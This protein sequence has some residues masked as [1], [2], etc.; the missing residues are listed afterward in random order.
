MDK[1]LLCSVCKYR[2]KVSLFKMVEDGQSGQ[3]HS[4][5]APTQLAMGAAQMATAMVGQLRVKQTGQL[6]TLRVGQQTVG[7]L[8]PTSKAD[9]KIG[10][11]TYNDEY[12][13]RCHARIDVV[14]TPMGIEHRLI[15]TG[16]VN[17]PA[18]NGKALMHGD[19]VVLKFGDVIRL[20][21]T[22]IILE[23]PCGV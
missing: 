1:T 18:V 15:E 2:A 6:F 11:A 14:Q 8:S 5:A 16:A 3:E 21:Q 7:R 23:K 22:D 19:E 17:L 4:Y 13:S 12:M 10:T 20:G 9:I